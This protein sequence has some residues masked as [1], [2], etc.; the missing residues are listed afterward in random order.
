MA[1]ALHATRQALGETLKE[2]GRGGS[3]NRSAGRLRDFM[4]A[5]EVALAVVLLAGAGMLIRG[6]LQLQSQETGF[7]ANSIATFRVALGW[8]RYINH[9]TIA[10]YYERALEALAQ[11]PGVEGVAFVPNPPLAR[12]E[13]PVPNT[14]QAEGQPVD[15]ALRNPYVVHQ[16]ISEDYFKLMRI[17]LK[18]GRFF[19]KF[20]AQ[21]SE[22]VAI[23]S[24]RLA[25][26]LWPGGDAIGKRLLYNP[27]ASKPGQFRRVVGV[28]G[29]VQH[30]ELGG[31]AS[32]DM[33]VSY[34]QVQAANQYLLVKTRLGMREFTEKAERALWAID[35]E[36]SL[37]DFQ[38]YEQ[39][40]LDSIWQLRVSRTLMILFGAVALMLA[41]IGI[42]GV[43]SYLVGQRTR[44]MG[45][46][47]ALGARA[48][49]VQG[50]IVRRGVMLTSAGLAAGLLGA[51]ILGRILETVL[52][53]IPGAD[54]LSF[55][56]AV[57]T[58]LAVSVAASAVPAWRA[59]HIDPAVTLRQE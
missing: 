52:R 45:I 53:G 11:I 4:I 54:P 37:F 31:E 1:P 48:T 8:K 43:M 24:E 21:G 18:S 2:G 39:R 29:S 58:L 23:V 25:T 12:Q 44:E 36:Q 28:V 55:S 57:V 34:R 47:L 26:R 33:Y 56:G 42:Y 51:F 46:R 30:R 22:P 20:D 38:T 40:I 59:S 14:V 13:E 15:E 9:E 6:F 17:P 41:A 50:M 49:S 35:P 16:V 5:A 32:L 27:R 7:R 3:A 10:R 19:S